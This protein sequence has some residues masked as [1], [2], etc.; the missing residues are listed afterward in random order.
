MLISY[1]GVAVDDDLEVVALSDSTWRVTDKGFPTD[2]QSVL[3]Y[4][5][6]VDGHFTV[7]L[8]YPPPKTDAV[9]DCFAA[10][11]AL[12]SQRRH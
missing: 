6:Q 7:S 12:V 3:A 10:A 11:I 9:V 5:E 1:Q 2:P 4:L 8:M